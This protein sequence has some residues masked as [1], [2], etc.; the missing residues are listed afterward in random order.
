M[1]DNPAIR[2]FWHALIKATISCLHMKYWDATTF[3]WDNA[4][5]AIRIAEYKQ[6]IR[7]FSCKYAVHRNDHLADGLGSV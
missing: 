7:L 6:R 4:Q 5:A 1:V 2:F 3:C